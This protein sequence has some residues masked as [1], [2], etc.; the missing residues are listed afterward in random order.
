MLGL[1]F[2]YIHAIKSVITTYGKNQLQ[3]GVSLWTY[4]KYLAI[5]FLDF[6]YIYVVDWLIVSANNI[7]MIVW[8]IQNYAF[9]D[10]SM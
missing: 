1:E 9:R 7:F 5:L 8:N 6:P 10:Y 2:M 3:Y 4:Q